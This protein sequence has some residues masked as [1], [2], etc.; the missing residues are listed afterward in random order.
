MANGLIQ[1]SCER[2]ACAD[3]V[4]QLLH[5]H[6]PQSRCPS[7]DT[8]VTSEHFARCTSVMGDLLGNVR[9][10]CSRGCHFSVPLKQLDSHEQACNPHA[11]PPPGMTTTSDITLGEVLAAPLDAPLCPDEQLVCTRL[12]KRALQESDNPS[13]LVLKTGGQVGL[14]IKG[15]HIQ[16]AHLIYTNTHTAESSVPPHSHTPSLLF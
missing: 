4:V 14:C 10:K 3:C 1:L 12:V 7:C 8:P 2:L 15:I 13:L 11:S 16:S 5:S 9:I 6:G